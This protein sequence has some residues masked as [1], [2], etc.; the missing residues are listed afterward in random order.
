MSTVT[1]RGHAIRGSGDR[2][3][4]QNQR[5]QL[6]HLADELENDLRAWKPQPGGESTA[7]H[8]RSEVWARIDRHRLAA[9]EYL[10][11]IKAYDAKAIKLTPGEADSMIRGVQ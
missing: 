1:I 9:G 2:L 8:I 6:I 4:C 3:H 5:D 7:A 11:A 10:I